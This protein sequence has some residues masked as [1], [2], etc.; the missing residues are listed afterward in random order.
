[1]MQIQQRWLHSLE[2]KGN[3][4]T[5]IEVGNFGISF[6]KAIFITW[7]AGLNGEGEEEEK[8]EEKEEEEGEEEEE[9]KYF[10]H[11]FTAWWLQWPG[12][13]SSQELELLIGL[14]VGE[15]GPSTWVIFYYFPMC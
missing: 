5:L 12:Q 1:M 2:D 15:R 13:G 11:W 14:H 6:F 7:K 8:E 3:S 10:I 4:I 9:E